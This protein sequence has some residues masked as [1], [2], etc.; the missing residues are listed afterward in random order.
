MPRPDGKQDN[1]GFTVLD[2]PSSNQS[3]PHVLDLYFRTLSKQTTEINQPSTIKSV[4]GNNLKAI[5]SWIRNI[6]ALQKNKPVQTV[7][8]Q[9]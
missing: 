8:Y 6:S 5:D 1:L 2:E 9:R 7:N 4:D 3:D